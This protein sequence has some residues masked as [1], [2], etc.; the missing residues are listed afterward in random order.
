MKEEFLDPEIHELV[1]F[2]QIPLRRF[3]G[4]VLSFNAAPV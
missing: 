3:C 2:F 1:P 4:I